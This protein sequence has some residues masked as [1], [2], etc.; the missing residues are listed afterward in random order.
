MDDELYT[1]VLTG[2]E[3]FTDM[4]FCNIG[5]ICMVHRDVERMLQIGTQGE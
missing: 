2:Q 5:C 4:S 1:C 3:Q